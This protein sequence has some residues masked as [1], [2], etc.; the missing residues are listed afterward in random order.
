MAACSASLST[1]GFLDV[2][3]GDWC[4]SASR[5]CCCWRE[6]VDPASKRA[7]ASA[8]R[9]ALLKVAMVSAVRKSE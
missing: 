2:A 6:E 5:G 4:E 1:S 8:A 3:S 7:S 9:H